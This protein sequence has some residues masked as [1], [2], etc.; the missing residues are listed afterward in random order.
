MS[1]DNYY[2]QFTKF[3]FKSEVEKAFHTLEGLLKGIAIDGSIN[4]EE[5]EEIT[6]W[7]NLNRSILSHHPF[8]TLVTVLKTAL[9]DGHIND[10]ERADILW[11]CSQ[12]TSFDNPYYDLVASD[13]H[14]LQG[15]LHG[16]MADNKIEPGE[17]E[18]LEDWLGEND[19]LTGVYPYDE[20]HSLITHVMDDG[21]LSPEESKSLKAFF[22]DFADLKN[23]P[24]LDPVEISEL[25]SS[26]N[27][28]GICAVHPAISFP[29]QTFSFTGES[30]KASR[31]GIKHRIESRGGRYKNALA[32][33]TDYLI[34]GDDGSPCWAFSCY[35][36]KVE[37]AMKMRR[38]GHHIQ[39]IH[40]SDFWNAI[41]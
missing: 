16:I 25:K 17:I 1:S 32:E 34:V 10:E 26:I 38:A 18:Q 30:S 36:R 6:G 2:Y 37:Q 20:L 14:R 12:Y 15:I 33:E 7:F 4:H 13:I 8:S 39:I 23:A 28:T 5:I 40:E 3:M 29:D 24:N 19:H 27:T 11:L 22:A 9:S 35:G 41:G 31:F 21:I